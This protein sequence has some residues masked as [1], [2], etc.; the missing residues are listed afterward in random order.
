[1]KKVNEKYTNVIH[2]KKNVRIAFYVCLSLQRY[3]DW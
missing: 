1:M 3:N 2:T